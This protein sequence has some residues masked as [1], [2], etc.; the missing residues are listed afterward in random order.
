M[1]N[2]NNHPQNNQ[3]GNGGNSGGQEP[4]GGKQRRTFRQWFSDTKHSFMAKPAGR[5]AVRALKGAG[6]AGVG[7]AGFAIGRKTAAPTKVLITVQDSNG[8]KVCED[9]EATPDTEPA[10][11]TAE[12]AEETTEE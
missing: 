9:L 5:W 4:N 12:P 2:H 11:E 6:L 3:N 10:E 1:S 8:N 7:A